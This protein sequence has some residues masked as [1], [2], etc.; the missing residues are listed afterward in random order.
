M[1]TKDYYET[2]IGIYNTHLANLMKSIEAETTNEVT[3][4]DTPE[5]VGGVLTEDQYATTY[6]K[7]KST[8]KSDMKTPI[9][10]LKDIQDSLRNVWKEWLLHFESLFLPLEEN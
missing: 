8:S 2:I 5:A 3:F 7:T 10:R 6:T 1:D 9:E 4:N